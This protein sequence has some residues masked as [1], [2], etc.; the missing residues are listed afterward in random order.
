MFCWQTP[1]YDQMA[2]LTDEDEHGNRANKYDYESELAGCD[3]TVGVARVPL[4]LLHIIARLLDD[5]N[6]ETLLR[7]W[8]LVIAETFPEYCLGKLRSTYP[9][10][11]PGWLL[12]G[13]KTYEVRTSRVFVCWSEGENGVQ[14]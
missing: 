7:S 3:F 12:Q 5:W 4:I 13:Y 1:V 2:R 14:Y 9:S 6:G 10:L 11:L 8:M